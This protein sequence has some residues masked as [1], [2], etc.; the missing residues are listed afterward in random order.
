MA[1]QPANGGIATCP[2]N[3]R[4]I[5]NRLPTVHHGASLVE[6]CNA[7]PQSRHRS[8][9]TITT[10]KWVCQDNCHAKCTVEIER[11]NLA[12]RWHCEVGWPVGA[13]R[14]SRPSPKR[15]AGPAS[16]TPHD[17]ARAPN[18]QRPFPVSRPLPAA[19][20][21]IRYCLCFDTPFVVLDRR[22]PARSDA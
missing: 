9:H 6:P 22:K 11:M 13:T 17:A 1:P 20:H 8:N 16:P 18:P 2:R 10:H 7:N 14:P 5:F 21:L 4:D 3:R 12:W 15:P 19:A